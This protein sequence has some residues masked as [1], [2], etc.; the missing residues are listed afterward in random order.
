[1]MPVAKITS[2][3]GETGVVFSSGANV[4]YNHLAVT[5]CVNTPTVW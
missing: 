5:V 2:L 1:M 4:A 3:I